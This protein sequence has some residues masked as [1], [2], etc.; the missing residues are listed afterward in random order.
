MPIQSKRI[1]LTA[2]GIDTVPGMEQEITSGSVLIREW[3]FHHVAL[4]YTGEHIKP[5][6]LVSSILSVYSVSR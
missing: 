1:S 2:L 4:C 6:Q 3:A 5:D